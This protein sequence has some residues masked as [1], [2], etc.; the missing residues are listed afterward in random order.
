M[1][2]RVP[3]LFTA[4]LATSLFNTSHTPSPTSATSGEPASTS[5]SAT[6]PSAPP[7]DLTATRWRVE[8]LN[9]EPPA[10]GVSI[11]A[12]FSSDG[13]IVGSG[14]CNRYRARFTTSG[15]AIEVVGAI[16]ATRMACVPPVMAQEA[17]YFAALAAA[18]TFAVADDRLT[19]RSDSGTTVASF[20]G[21]SQVLTGTSW[22]VVA[23]NDGKS[24]L[25]SVL[26][27]TRPSLTFNAN[28]CF[29]GF[30]GCNHLSG[31]FSAQEG[32][33][34]VPSVAST[35]MFCVEPEGVMDQED[36]ISRALESATTY[37]IEGDRLTLRTAEDA[38]AIE[39]NRDERPSLAD[40]SEQTARSY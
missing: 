11:T 35:E 26:K 13:M 22:Q 3:L 10:Q 31:R 19:L 33:V 14:G 1:D 21:Q 6:T 34:T 28:G 12:S 25:V 38:I 40:E 15:D 37:V 16:A 8:E 20:V 2:A 27:D 30:G 7:G 39:L 29:S 4:V 23:Y 17:S 5:P 24:A 18:R 32:K 9:G 36:A